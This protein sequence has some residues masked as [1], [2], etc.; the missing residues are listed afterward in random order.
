MKIVSVSFR[1]LAVAA[2]LLLNGCLSVQAIYNDAYPGANVEQLINQRYRPMLIADYP[3]VTI[4]M[5]TCPTSLDLTAKR[6]GFCSIPVG[7]QQLPIRVTLDK[8]DQPYV[9]GVGS[10]FY[11]DML[12]AL[13]RR[14]AFDWYEIDA[15]VTCPPPLFRIVEPKQIV[16]CRWNVPGH[17][18]TVRFQG[19]D[20][21][22]TITFL[23]SPETKRSRPLTGLVAGSPRPVPGAAIARQMDFVLQE[24]LILSKRMAPGLAEHVQFSPTVCPATI[25]VSRIKRAVCSVSV[26]GMI[27]PIDVWF[28]GKSWQS[29][30][31]KMAYRGP[32]LSTYGEQLFTRSAVAQGD[33]SAIH[34]DCKLP[35]KVLLYATGHTMHCAFRHGD[36]TGSLSVNATADGQVT[37]TADSD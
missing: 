33:M 24:R 1:S 25:A 10:F 21:N 8:S 26:G 32:G 7:G 22:G 30:T 23:G 20:N 31:E 2:S 5:G 29:T 11:S 15:P 14:Y 16:Q 19:V 9:Q 13:G 17:A 12:D 37:F 28:D 35:Q 34:V 3:S 36:Q 6:A 27:D 18:R 4:G